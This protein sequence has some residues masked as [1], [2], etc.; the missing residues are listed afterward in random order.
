MVNELTTDAMA[1]EKSPLSSIGTNSPVGGH[2]QKIKAKTCERDTDLED[3]YI[4]NM[5]EAVTGAIEEDDGRI[6]IVECRRQASLAH[7]GERR[8]PPRIAGNQT[9]VVEFQVTDVRK[10]ILSVWPSC[11]R[12]G[13]KRTPSFWRFSCELGHWRVELQAG[14]GTGFH[15]CSEGQGAQ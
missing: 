9:I 11:R 6:L 12:V 10:P 5:I 1:L 14:R 3:G 2:A 15:A 13:K 7:Y 4:L 8:V